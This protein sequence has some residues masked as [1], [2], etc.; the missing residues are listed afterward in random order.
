MVVGGDRSFDQQWLDHTGN[1]TP[2][3][4][5]QAHVGPGVE[6]HHRQSVRLEHIVRWQLVDFLQ[7]LNAQPQIIELP[8]RLVE[9]GQGQA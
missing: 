3:I 7:V 2:D 6:Q 4:Q 8:L 1:Q 5:C 9:N